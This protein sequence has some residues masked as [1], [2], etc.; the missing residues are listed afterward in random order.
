MNTSLIVACPQCHRKNRLPANRAPASAHCGSCKQLLFQGSPIAL[1]GVS[2]DAHATADLPLLVDF[3]APWCGPCKAFAPV[4]QQAAQHFEPALR[5]GKVNTE[6]QPAL[7]SRFGIR[8]VPTLILI[9]HGRE[10]ARISGALPAQQLHQWVR[11]HLP[12]REGL[13]G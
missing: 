3:W 2:F 11:R 6:E 5:L 9:A 13:R 4:F 12:Q 8:S 10:L 7:A 1:S